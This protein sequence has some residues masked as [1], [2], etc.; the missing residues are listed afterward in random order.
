M[1]KHLLLIAVLLGFNT[2]MANPVDMNEAQA[3]GQKFV[4]EHFAMSHRSNALSLA[5][6]AYADRGE[7]CFY[8]FNVGNDGFIILS[9]DDFY[10]PIIGYSENGKFDYDNIPPALQDYLEGIVMERNMHRT[11]KRSDRK[12]VV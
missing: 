1:K 8:V 9:A 7:V 5:Y 3:L 6:T 10:R 12:S 2:L 11:S 4:G